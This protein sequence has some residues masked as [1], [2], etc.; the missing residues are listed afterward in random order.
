MKRMFSLSEIE[1]YWDDYKDAYRLRVLKDGK[2]ELISLN[3]IPTGCVRAEKVKL[4]NHMEFPEFL[5]ERVN[6]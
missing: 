3:Q 2:W 1:V 5:K 6:A 4:S